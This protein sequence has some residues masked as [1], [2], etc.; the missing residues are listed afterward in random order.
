MFLLLIF[1]ENPP[2]RRRKEDVYLELRQKELDYR[3]E[4]LQFEKE[5]FA[6]EKRERLAM[7]DLLSKKADS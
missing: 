3:R 6:L 7:I 2:K 5:R 1:T 4:Q